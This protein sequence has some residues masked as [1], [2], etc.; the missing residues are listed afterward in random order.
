MS[1]GAEDFLS[2]LRLQIFQDKVTPLV[3]LQEHFSYMFS[4]IVRER[5]IFRKTVVGDWR[6]NYLSGSHLQSQVKSRRQMMVFMPLVVVLIGQFCHD[7]IG[8]HPDDHAKQITDT[9]GFKPFTKNIS[10]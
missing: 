8:R 10:G 6:F 9:L 4:V 2:T 7:V 5:V 1:T 3:A